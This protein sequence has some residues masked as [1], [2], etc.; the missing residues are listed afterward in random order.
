MGLYPFA[1]AV[2][3]SFDDENRYSMSF[4]AKES[5]IAHLGPFIF[6]QKTFIFGHVEK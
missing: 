1:T 5:S 3:I 4:E 6:E 2:P